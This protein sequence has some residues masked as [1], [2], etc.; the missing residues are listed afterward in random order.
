MRGFMRSVWLLNP[1][2]P[3]AGAGAAAQVPTQ[4]LSLG[5]TA[6]HSSALQSDPAAV[7]ASTAMDFEA[8]MARNRQFAS[9][10]CRV[11]DVPDPK[12]GQERPDGQGHEGGNDISE[13]AAISFSSSTWDAAWPP[14]RG[15]AQGRPCARLGPLPSPHLGAERKQPGGQSLARERIA[16]LTLP[17]SVA[18][19]ATRTAE[20]VRSGW[21]P[22]RCSP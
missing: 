20:S 18:D 21:L 8:F 11:A 4:C 14:A 15:P 17:A 5:K 12:Q 22:A 6:L 19:V 1:T 13:Q 7:V 10:R 3:S 9:E 2:T 16:A